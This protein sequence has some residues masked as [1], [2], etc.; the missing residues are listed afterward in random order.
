MTGLTFSERLNS[1]LLW[2]QTASNSIN[3]DWLLTAFK[4]QQTLFPFCPIPGRADGED[5]NPSSGTVWKFGPTSPREHWQ[6][7]SILPT[8][9]SPKPGIP[10]CSL[11]IFRG[12]WESAL[13]S[14]QRL[15]VQVRSLSPSLSARVA[16][17]VLTSRWNFVWR[18]HAASVRWSQ[19]SAVFFS[20]WARAMRCG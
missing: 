15:T 17:W 10:W 13:L 3:D 4:A 6:K 9:T 8:T 7:P 20:F 5:S 1:I 11:A 19:H 14:P 16:S 12:P 18:V 2:V